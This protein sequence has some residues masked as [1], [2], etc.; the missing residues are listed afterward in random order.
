MFLAVNQAKVASVSSNVCDHCNDKMACIL[1]VVTGMKLNSELENM[2][3]YLEQ[4]YDPVI[5]MY[6]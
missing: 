2:V 5:S 6:M 4:C 1:S 3:T